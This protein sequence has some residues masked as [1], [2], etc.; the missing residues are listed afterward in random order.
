M[1]LR[2]KPKKRILREKPDV[3]AVPTAIN[4]RWSMDFMH[5]QLTDGR[6]IRLFNVIDDFNREGLTIDID[7]SLPASRVVRSLNQIIE[8]RG[9]PRQIRCD[10][11]PEYV[12]R[13]LS[14]WAYKNNIQL[15]FIEPGNPQQNAYIERYNRTVRYDWLNQY[16]FHDVEEVQYYATQWLWTYNNERPNMALG[17][18]NPAMKLA[19]AA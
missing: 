18:L 8:W 9:K 11:G 1:N 7:F 17:G 12:S 4:E 15:L 3:L 13:L 14:D 16:L 10:N 6:S 5:D 19:M 2:I